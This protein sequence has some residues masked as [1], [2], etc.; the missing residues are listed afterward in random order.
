[1]KRHA[2]PR[3]FCSRRKRFMTCA[4]ID[5]M[6][7]VAQAQAET[8][9][10]DAAF[11]TYGRIVADCP[12]LDHRIATLQKAKGRVGAEQLERLFALEGARAKSAEERAKVAAVQHSLTAVAR[13]GSAPVNTAIQRLFRPGLTRTVAERAEPDVLRERHAKG[14]EQLGWF[15]Y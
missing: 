7:R 1:M 6:W 2:T 11:A 9:Q 13:P 12:D 4:R 5:N 8:G 15:Y 14:A 10:R 3:S